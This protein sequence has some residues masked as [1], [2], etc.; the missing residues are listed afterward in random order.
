MGSE[1]RAINIMFD[2]A[3]NYSKVIP[4]KSPNIEGNWSQQ[5]AYCRTER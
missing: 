2:I 4:A 1:S 3:G 5:P